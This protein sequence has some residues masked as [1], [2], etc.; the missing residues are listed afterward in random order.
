MKSSEPMAKTRNPEIPKI[1]IE[2]LSVL[3]YQT[4]WIQNT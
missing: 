1:L 4:H 2:Q 3:R